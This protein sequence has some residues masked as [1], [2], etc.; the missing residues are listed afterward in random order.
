MGG[1]EESTNITSNIEYVN[2]SEISYVA[3]GSFVPYRKFWVEIA[4]MHEMVVGPKAT[5][6]LVHG[7]RLGGVGCMNGDMI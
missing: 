1:D 3:S 2:S 6:N 5:D 7:N 4:L